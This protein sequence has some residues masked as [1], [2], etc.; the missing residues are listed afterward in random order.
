M[1]RIILM[2]FFFWLTTGQAE[3]VKVKER[4]VADDLIPCE[5]E[6]QSGV[7][8]VTISVPINGNIISKKIS[9]TKVIY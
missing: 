4:G 6:N 5:W 2:L 3:I 7:P 9:P 8:C 1:V